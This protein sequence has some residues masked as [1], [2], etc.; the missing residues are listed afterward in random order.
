MT[1]VENNFEPA[2]LFRR[3]ADGDEAAFTQAFYHYNR[4]IFPYVLKKLQSEDD[5]K[6]VVQDAFLKLW[7]YREMLKETVSPEGY[8]Y[9]IVAN[10]VQDHF[11]K[12]ARQHKLMKEAAGQQSSSSQ[13]SPEKEIIYRE[14]Q[15][16]YE[17]AVRNLPP[18]GRFAY[19]LREEG[20]S[21]EEIGAK[22]GISVNTVR[23]HLV[24]AGKSI[25][26]YVKDK[27]LRI[28][29]WLF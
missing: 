18:Q 20:F 8:L 5:A 1:P 26:E 7:Q 21:Y 23:N 9:R 16:L 6:E 2:E 17:Q 13:A 25:K 15:G 27:G 3:I 11:R 29:S 10:L 24:R 14:T 28:I 22:L 12:K 4:F 19:E